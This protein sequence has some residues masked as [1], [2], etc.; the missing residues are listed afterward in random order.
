MGTRPARWAV[1]DIVRIRS[2]CLT[3][4][5]LSEVLHANVLTRAGAR[6]DLLRA[7]LDPPVTPHGRA[8]DWHL[9]GGRAMPEF[10]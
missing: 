9:G 2:H 10:G 1:E 7:D 4:N 8:T 3:R 6:A 5:V